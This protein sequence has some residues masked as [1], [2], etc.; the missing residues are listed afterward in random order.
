[1][2]PNI[3]ANAWKRWHWFNLAPDETPG[4]LSM[5]TSALVFLLSSLGLI[6]LPQFNN[7]PFILFV[8]FYVLWG[9]RFIGIWHPH[10]LPG[11]GVILLCAVCAISIMTWLKLGF[12]GR[13]AGIAI[14]TTALGLKLLELKSQRDI[15]LLSCLAFISACT[16]FLYQQS[17]FMTVYI[18]FTSCTLLSTLVLSNHTCTPAQANKTAFTLMLQGLPLALIMFI[19]FPR[20]EAPR[21]LLFD[22]PNTAI[23]GLAESMEP[24]AISR[25]GLSDQLAFR[26]KFSGKIPPL[27]QRYWR[28]PVLSYTDGKSWHQIKPEQKRIRTTRIDFS[29]DAYQYTLLMQPQQLNYVYALEFASDYPPSLALNSNYQL[30][31]TLGSEQHREYQLTSFS[32]SAR[33]TLSTHERTTNLQL[34]NEPT[35]SITSLIE[36]LDGES[37]APTAFISNLLNYF[38]TQHF[39]Y[40]LTP[41]L[42]EEQPIEQ[43]LFDIRAGFCSHYATAFVYLMRVAGIPA[44]VITGY[45]GGEMN[46]VGEFMEIRQANAHAWTEVWLENKGWTRID[47][48]AAVAPERIEQNVNIDQQIAN[49]TVTFTPINNRQ[50]LSWMRHMRYVWNNLDYNWQRWIINYGSNNQA[51][52]LEFLRLFNIH[53]LMHALLLFTVLIF[54][55]ICIVLLRQSHT[56]VKDPVYL[57]YQKF[58]RKIN[59]ITQLEIKTGE[60]PKDFARRICSHHPNLAN[61]VNSI[62]S[63]YIK[64][65]YQPR[66]DKSDMLSLKQQI[67]MFNKHALKPTE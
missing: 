40:T 27:Q 36:Q 12:L 66:H 21:W 15:F 52:L 16:L 8:M 10:Y 55:V 42:M 64:I 28:G 58:C 6:V 47:P 32:R 49:G 1:M 41:P 50:A 34:P 63:L 62:T 44:R 45:Q 35:E 26:V 4:K 54:G 38:K 20:L 65:R 19:F 46:A 22:D 13:D 51:V 59:R 30:V 39:R 43:F 60:G 48:T 14:F 53:N 31:S 11:R 7:L 57:L 37:G 67:R 33:Q 29:G 5:N 56:P 17:I 23:S 61:Q 25:L 3:I 9:W 2:A 18:I 24:G